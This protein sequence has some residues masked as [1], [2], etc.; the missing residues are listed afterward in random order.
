MNSYFRH[1]YP[2]LSLYISILC[3]THSIVIDPTVNV[4]T[5]LR[6]TMRNAHDGVIINVQYLDFQGDYML[7]KFKEYEKLSGSKINPIALTQANWF[8]Q[9]EE[10]INGAGFV[11]LYAI[12]GNW[13]PTFVEQNGLLD[14]TDE[15]GNAVGLDWFDI[16]PAVRQGVASYKNR[17]YTVP[18]DGDVRII[19]S[20]FLQ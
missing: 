4:S 3:S 9:I 7:H 6:E 12:F 20:I 18:L 10:D 19:Y 8:D 15:I 11:D 17:V 5:P 16:M 1:L 13:I 2:I 14:I